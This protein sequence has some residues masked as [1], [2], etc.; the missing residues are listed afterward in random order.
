[1]GVNRCPARR[2]AAS[3][4][5]AEQIEVV[6]EVLKE[7]R[8]RLRF[9]LNVGLHYLNLVAPG[10]HPL[11]RRGPAHPPGQ[12][13]GL[14]AGGR[15][16]HPRRAVHRPALARPAQ[17]AQHPAQ[18]ARHGQHRAGGRAR[19]RDHARRRL[20]DRPGPGRGR[21]GRRGGRR[22]HARPGDAPTRTR[23]PGSTFPG[24]CRS[25]APN[26]RSRRPAAR[27]ADAQRGA[28]VQPEERHRPLPARHRH[29]RHRR[30]GSGKII[31]GRRDALPGPG[32]QPDGRAVHPRPLRPPGRAG[33]ARQGDRHHPGADRAHPALQPGHLRGRLR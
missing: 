22:G 15:A 6:G 12:P 23:S 32:A 11:G 2:T 33:P 24:D 10:P 5:N 20:A 26:G 21:Q 25:A 9:M 27:L 28:P 29:L 17:P 30:L 19:R 1:M 31:A 4:L 18:A 3:S 16:V 8:S 14:R 7:L 13:A